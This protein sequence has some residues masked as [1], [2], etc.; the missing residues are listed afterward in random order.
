VASANFDETQFPSPDEVDIG[1][2]PNRHAAFGLG[3]HR[4]VGS[5]IARAAIQLMLRHTL[6]RMPDYVADEASARPY[7]SPIVNG[8]ITLPVTFTPG[9]PRATTRTLPI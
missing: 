7:R 4:C 1:R 3:I 9:R 5:H 6:E 8:W 2:F